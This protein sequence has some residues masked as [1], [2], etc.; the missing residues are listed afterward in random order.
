MEILNKNKGGRP[1]KILSRTF[2]L[3]VACNKDELSIIKEKAE[4]TQLSVSGFLRTA[5]VGSQIDIRKNKALPKEVLQVT[6][7]LNHL[8][9]NINSLA[10]KNN[11]AENFNAIERA[12]LKY[13]AAQVHQLANDIKNY[14]Q[15]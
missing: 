11:R 6:A 2:R 5:A 13:L 7:Q 1:K 12:E 3:R 15:K 10:Y 8:A 14:L 4:Q 9:A